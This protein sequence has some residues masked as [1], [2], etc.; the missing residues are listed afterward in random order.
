MGSMRI[1]FGYDAH[2]FDEARPLVL[3]GVR[4]PD[5]PGLLGHSDG[6]AIAHAVADALLGAAALALWV[7]LGCSVI[8]VT[9]RL[10]TRRSDSPMRST[11][12]ASNSME[13][14]SFHSGSE[15]GKCRPMSPK[16]AAPRSASVTAW[17]MASPSECPR[18]PG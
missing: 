10:Q 1:G 3:G 18:R 8:T 7:I 14:A 2:R 4:I 12:R 15:G 11:T 5:H 16:A 6:D 17:A 13:S 9:S